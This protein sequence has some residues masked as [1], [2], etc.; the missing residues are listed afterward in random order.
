[1]NILVTTSSFGNSSFP[2]SVN[3]IMNPYKRKLT[4]SE[5]IELVDKYRPAGIIAGVEPLT[6]KVMEKAPEL[7]VIS[8]CGTGMDSVDLVA[9]RSLGITVVNTPDAPTPSVA[10]LTIGLMLC[11]ARHINTM[12]T[13][14]RKG[15]WKGPQGMLL[16]EKTVGIVGCGRIGTYVAELVSAFGCRVLGYDPYIRQHGICTIVSMDELLNE[17]DIV[18]LHVPYSQA[19]HHIIGEAELG[20]MKSAAL[21]INAA[22]GGLVDEEALY[23]ALKQGVIAGAAM[24]CFELEPYKGKLTEL[25]NTVLTSHIGSGA[26]ETRKIMEA[27]AVENLL[28]VLACGL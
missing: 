14:I 1:M 5:A 25:D 18:T 15:D 8:R 16:K 4:E 11:L 24:D 3:V 7:K 27:Q 6:R 20:R 10:E 12:D 23:A 21:L 19:N 28:K 9:A 22:R 17:A 2:D 13:G 26:V